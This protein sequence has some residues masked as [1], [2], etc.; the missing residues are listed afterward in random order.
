M[1][2]KVK[3]GAKEAALG[4]VASR[5]S[6]HPD[7]L[8]SAALRVMKIGLELGL[9]SG[10]EDGAKSAVCVSVDFDVTSGER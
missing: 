4:L 6:P 3:R 8:S 5:G 2:L 10:Y 1:S 7:A 9:E